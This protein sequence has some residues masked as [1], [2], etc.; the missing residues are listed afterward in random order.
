MSQ[1]FQAM[2]LGPL[3][4]MMGSNKIGTVFAPPTQ[5]D[6]DFLGELYEAGKLVPIIDRRYPLREVPEAPRY[7]GEGGARGKVVITVAHTNK[8]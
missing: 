6:L 4:S 7:Y 2:L 3:L 8:T 5:Q 1:Y